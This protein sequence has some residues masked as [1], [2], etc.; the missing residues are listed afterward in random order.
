[1]VDSLKPFLNDATERM[2][3]SL[4]HFVSESR[5]IRTG[6]ATPGLIESIRVDYYGSKTPLNQVASV[7]VPD[8]RSLVVKP[9]DAGSLKDIERAILGSDLGFNPSIEG[10]AL[11]ISIPPLSEDQRKKLAA[12]VKTLAEETRV[13]LRNVRRDVIKELETANK[14]KSGDDVVTDDD[15]RLGKEKVQEVLKAFEK[16]VDETLSAKQSEIME[17]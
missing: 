17:V 2:Q 7:S 1:M 5:G 15:L 14:N 11:R 6:R 3:K 4:E 10:K 12:R 16:K 13:S 9:Y 8:P